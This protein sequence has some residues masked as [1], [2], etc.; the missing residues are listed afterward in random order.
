[1]GGRKILFLMIHILYREL[2]VHFIQKYDSL[3][4]LVFVEKKK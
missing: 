2:Y 3:N 1:M 4:Y